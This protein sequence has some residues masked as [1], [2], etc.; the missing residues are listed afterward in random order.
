MAL[1]GDV[2]VYDRYGKLIAVA[3]VKLEAS[4][5]DAERLRREL[6]QNTGAPYILVVTRKKTYIWSPAGRVVTEPTA[7][8]VD[9][10]LKQI[11]RDVEQVTSAGLR[12]VVHIWLSDLA[13]A[14]HDAAQPRQPD[15]VHAI[16]EGEVRFETAA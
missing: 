10:Y 6:E 5:K 15:F 12:A 16:A 8:F 14:L 2:L 4:M 3:A 13:W 1:R 9:P 11:D 7:R